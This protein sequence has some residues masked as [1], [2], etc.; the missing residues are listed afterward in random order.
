M[1]DENPGQWR[2]GFV[3]LEEPAKASKKQSK[4]GSSKQPAKKAPESKKRA[5]GDKAEGKKKRVF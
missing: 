1:R 3:E 5:S 2:Y 4:A